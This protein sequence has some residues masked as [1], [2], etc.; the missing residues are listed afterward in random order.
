MNNGGDD[1][2]DELT[3][4]PKMERITIVLYNF[5]RVTHKV[6]E[7]MEVTNATMEKTPNIMKNAMSSSITK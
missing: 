2:N 4:F 6:A 3:F 5:E 1:N 7:I